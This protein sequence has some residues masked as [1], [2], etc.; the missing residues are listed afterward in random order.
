M[1]RWLS[2]HGPLGPGLAGVICGL[3][4]VVAL[5]AVLPPTL[6]VLFWWFGVWFPSSH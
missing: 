1:F 6:K 5:F 3:L 2:P 4:F